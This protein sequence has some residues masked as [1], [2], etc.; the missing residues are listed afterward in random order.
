MQLVYI[1]KGWGDTEYISAEELLYCLKEDGL[2]TTGDWDHGVMNYIDYMLIFGITTDS[3]YG[4]AHI[5][6]Y[7]RN[8]GN[9][10]I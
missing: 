9:Y 6:R 4:D 3:V 2:Y 10:P 7:N 5:M 1:P 8:I